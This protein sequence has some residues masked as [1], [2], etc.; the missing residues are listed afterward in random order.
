MENVQT[1]PENRWS[2]GHKARERAAQERT[3]PIRGVRPISAGGM[4]LSI[5]T[6]R[7]L[8]RGGDVMQILFV[9]KREAPQRPTGAGLQENIASN[10]DD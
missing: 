6:R 4:W 3:H 9:R 5:G 10:H 2:A 7:E 8:L 1:G